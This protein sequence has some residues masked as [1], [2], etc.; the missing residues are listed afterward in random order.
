MF[1]EL[2]AAQVAMVAGGVKAAVTGG[3]MAGMETEA[4]PTLALTHVAATPGAILG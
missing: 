2:S 3:A 1:P 4:R